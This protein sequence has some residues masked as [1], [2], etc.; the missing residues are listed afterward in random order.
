MKKT[1]LVLFIFVLVTNCKTL[2]PTTLS[3]IPVPLII[4]EKPAETAAISSIDLSFVDQTYRGFV[5]EVI[6]KDFFLDYNGFVLEFDTLTKNTKWVCYL[7]CKDNLGNGEERSSNFRM[8]RRLGD[9]SP[10]DAAYR[11]SGYDRGHL[12]P[13]ADMGYSAES[14]YDSFFLTNASPQVPGFNRGIWKRLEEQV[15]K[16]AAEKDSLYIATGPVLQ[17]NLPS[18]GDSPIR[19][20]DYFYKVILKK[21]TENPQ[22]IAFI[23]KNEAA[24]GDLKSFAV[25]IDSVEVLTGINFFPLLSPLQESKAEGKFDLSFWFDN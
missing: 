23:L 21:D 18:M 16:F 6:S 15:R 13:A 25:S 4:P 5:P 14:M 2:E 19:V 22:G 8:E 7:L 9:F 1:V 10:R 3:K 11:N 17:A 24:T 20:P 12:A